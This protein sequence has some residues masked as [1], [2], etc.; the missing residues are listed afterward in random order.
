MSIDLLLSLV[1]YLIVIG[2][3]CWLLWWLIGFVGIPEPF[4]KIARGIVA[5]VAVVLLIGLLLSLVG[6]Q[7]FNVVPLR[8]R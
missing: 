6:G 2:A 4:N 3:I 7:S 1:I 8:L 5:V